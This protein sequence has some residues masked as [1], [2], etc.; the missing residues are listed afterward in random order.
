MNTVTLPERLFGYL[1]LEE[2]NKELKDSK[3]KLD[4]TEVREASEEE[5]EEPAIGGPPGGEDGNT[6]LGAP[7]MTK[8]F[9]S[10]FGMTFSVDGKEKKIQVTVRWGQYA[11]TH[12]ETIVN[13]NG[14]PKLVW[15]R[16]PIEGV[17]H[18]LPLTEGSIESFAP[19][20]EHGE[21]IVRGEVRRTKDTNWII[22]LFLVNKQVEP[23]MRRDE[24]WIFQPEMLVKA[25]D[26][27]PIF[28]KRPL[29]SDSLRLDPITRQEART[30]AML[31][32]HQVEFAV[33]HG[34]SVHAETDPNDSQKAIRISTRAIPKYDVPKQIHTTPAT[35]PDLSG[36]VLD[37]KELSETEDENLYDKLSGLT[38]AYEKW[39]QE[40]KAKIEDKTY[41]LELYREAANEAIQKCER[42]LN[43]I[44][45]GI[46][47]LSKDKHAADAFRFANQSMWLQRIHSIYASEVRKGNEI[48]IE[49][50]D[51]ENNRSWYPFQLAFIL[52]N[53]PSVTDLHHPD[54][55]NEQNAIADLLW[56]P[57]G[58]NVDLRLRVNSA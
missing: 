31:Y 40:E 15:K 38:N 58:Y 7:H 32:R 45:D 14:E 21:V 30:M 24:G 52:L 50:V 9:P 47:L 54:R 26:G 39:L 55:S 41:G 8:L 12:S 46:N 25:K 13:D 48:N 43:R 35:N 1:N 56:F 22:T 44:R 23:K 27:R 51:Q 20:P 49:E 34:V 42:A 28:C 36:L 19:D 2:L 18:I 16:I 57:T 6:D 33:G 53:L 29:I 17:P 3:I 37:M 10:S 4:W 11:R 5:S